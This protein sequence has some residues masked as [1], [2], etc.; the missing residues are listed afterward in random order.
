MVAEQG[1]RR[2][3]LPPFGDVSRS[4]AVITNTG[5]DGLPS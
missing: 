5:S 2:S 1:K 4:S 3:A